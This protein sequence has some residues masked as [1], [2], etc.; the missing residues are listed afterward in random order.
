MAGVL[1]AGAGAAAI[2][3]ADAVRYHATYTEPKA[4][5]SLPENPSHG[6]N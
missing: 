6:Q 1:L 5:T 2:A 3:I 4:P